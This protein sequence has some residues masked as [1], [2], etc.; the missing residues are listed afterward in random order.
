M[1]KVHW[2]CEDWVEPGVKYVMF[3]VT[4]E[5]GNNHSHFHLVRNRLE[6]HLAVEVLSV[7]AKLLVRELEGS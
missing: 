1:L 2:H 4:D 6:L 7:F 3:V 5:Y